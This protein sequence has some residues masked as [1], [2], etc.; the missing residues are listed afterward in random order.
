MTQATLDCKAAGASAHAIR[1]HYDLSNEFYALW[2]DDTRT[3]SAALWEPGDTLEQAQLRK[4]DHHARNCAA[5]PGGHYLDIG[6]GWGSTLFRLMR[7]YGAGSATGLTL[8]DAQAQYIE[9]QQVPGVTVKVQGWQVFDPPH[10]FDGIISIGA[11]E[12]FAKPDLSDD[13]M[14]A[15]YRAFFARCHAW[16]KPDCSLSLQTIAYGRASRA[17]INRFVLEQIFPESDLPSLEQIVRAAKGL[18]EV[19]ALRNDRHHYA[20]TFRHWTAR[21]SGAR[22]QAVALVGEDKVRTYQKYQGLF[23][24]G[25]HT[26]AMDLYR[27]HLRRIGK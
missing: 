23:T 11:F 5:G 26:G 14:V 9:A 25:F 15:A 4:L 12:H 8:S 27:L 13:D 18:F 1:H 16:L 22:A 19:V 3:Y 2:L 10:P 21:L 20:D 17:D 6:C 24:I 7:T